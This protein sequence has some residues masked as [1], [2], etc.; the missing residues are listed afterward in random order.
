MKQRTMLK[1]TFVTL[2]FAVVPMKFL[3][4]C[5]WY[6]SDGDYQFSLFKAVMP[7]FRTYSRLYYT[8]DMWNYRTED[9]DTV[10]AEK[11]ISVVNAKEWY[12]ELQG[13][14]SIQSIYHTL[15]EKDSFEY[16]SDTLISEHDSLT[17]YT[18]LHRPQLAAYLALIKKSEALLNN[19]DP[20]TFESTNVASTGTIESFIAEAEYFQSKVEDPF[21][22][23]RLAFLL[24]RLGYYGNN[25]ELVGKNY[26]RYFKNEVDDTW[27]SASAHFYHALTMQPMERNM[28]F[29][30]I[31]DMKHERQT[32]IVELFDRDEA[33]MLQ[34]LKNASTDREKSNLK[35]MYELRNPGRSFFAIEEIFQRDPENPFLPFL[36][37][38]EINKMEDWLYSY[39]LTGQL[40]IQQYDIRNRE[41]ER[42]DEGVVK[43]VKTH[44]LFDANYDNDVRYAQ[45]FFRS[46]EGWKLRDKQANNY[47]RLMRCHLGLLLN[48]TGEVQRILSE[49]KSSPTLTN[50]MRN[51]VLVEEIFLDLVKNK[52][53]TQTNEENILKFAKSISPNENEWYS[54]T[55]ELQFQKLMLLISSLLES[56]GHQA[57]AFFYSEISN[58]LIGEKACGLPDD[59]WSR[60]LRNG[61]TRECERGFAIMQNKNKTEYDKWLTSAYFTDYNEQ[62]A[63]TLGFRF[64]D[65]KSTI[66]IQR[67]QWEQA[68][69]CIKDI[70]D[71][72]WEGGHYRYYCIGDPFLESP[73]TRDIPRDDNYQSR[74]FT[75]PEFLKE[76]L[77]LKKL[78]NNGKH[79]HGMVEYQL[80]NAM[81]N[82]SSDGAFWFFYTNWSCGNTCIDQEL[83]EDN[84]Y[85]CKLASKYYDKAMRHIS[86]RS[87]A[88][89]C[90]WAQRFCEKR[91]AGFSGY[92]QMGYEESWRPF[93]SDAFQFFNKKFGLEN[94]TPIAP[95]EDE[96]TDCGILYYYQ[97]HL[98]KQNGQVGY[99]FMNEE[100]K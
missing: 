66:H 55:S 42:Y 43:E 73:I 39:K 57:E 15:Y 84:F 28:E 14:V 46:L 74:H 4:S 21:I 86:D 34:C 22:S 96:F 82:L 44:R 36:V 49:L 12:T 77:R 3:E 38:R 98:L 75:K 71:Y 97:D 40:T 1:W 67:G 68:Y 61:D 45:S 85:T 65:I 95:L 88:V 35:V 25:W 72:Y 59:G 91:E 79:D 80:G 94:K 58:E 89:M 99:L 47:L 81:L 20:W 33:T 76:F 93:S 8:R 60:L 10:D 19:E 78:S 100:K 64:L 30:R 9:Q 69:S 26:S 70:P 24:I 6:G 37:Y 17:H 16:L 2:L 63:D 31:F 41:V 48:K 87:N 62:P 18:T 52:S 83:F 32:R 90:F 92:F 5:G 53:I 54:S 50:D 23:K 56:Y 11:S 27:L 29:V 51:Q 7:E 13:Q